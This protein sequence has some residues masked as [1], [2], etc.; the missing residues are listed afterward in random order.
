MIYKKGIGQLLRPDK[1]SIMFEK[2][3]S[4]ENQVATMV[5]LKIMTGVF[6]D[7]Y[8]GSSVPEGIMKTGKFQST[9]EKTVKRLSDWIE[10]YAS[11]GAKEV[12]ITLVIEALSVY[13]MRI[14]KFL[15]WTN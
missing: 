5:I 15:T 8:L 13:A 3:C 9:K 11:S 12:Q 14:F 6:D 7:K 4:L 10:K 1:C 2:S